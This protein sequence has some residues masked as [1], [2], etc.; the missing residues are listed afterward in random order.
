MVMPDSSNGFL[1]LKGGSYK[2]RTGR[3]QPSVVTVN[4]DKKWSAVSY[5]SKR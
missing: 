5:K 4:V 2:G 3:R 1:A